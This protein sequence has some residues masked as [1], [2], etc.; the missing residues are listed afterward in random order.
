MT[1]LDASH[2]N[3]YVDLTLKGVSILMKIFKRV[4]QVV[5]VDAWLALNELCKSNGLLFQSWG[6]NE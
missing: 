1:S 6:S 5:D 2:Q 4:H 3:F